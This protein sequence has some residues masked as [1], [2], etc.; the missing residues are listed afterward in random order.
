ML[1]E[2]KFIDSIGKS[3]KTW[4]VLKSPSLPNKASVFGTH[5]LKANNKMTFETNSTLD[6][7]K[8]TVLLLLF[9]FIFWK[10]PPNKC[11]IN[12]PL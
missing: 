1:F 12:F 6:S 8:I 5:T 4:K 7:S 9:Y 3:R 11:T 10:K 2:N